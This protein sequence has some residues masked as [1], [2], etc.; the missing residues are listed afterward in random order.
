MENKVELTPYTGVNFRGDVIEFDQ[1][2]VRFN[3]RTVGYLC[4]KPGSR[5]MPIVNLPDATWDEVCRKC[6]DLRKPKGAVLRPFPIYVP[7]Q[8]LIEQQEEIEVDE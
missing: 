3:G 5:L 7:P 8:A 6:E 1:W 4:H 2:N